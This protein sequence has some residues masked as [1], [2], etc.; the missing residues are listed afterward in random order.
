M[1]CPFRGPLRRG[2]P[3]AWVL[4]RTVVCG[5]V[6]TLCPPSGSPAGEARGEAGLVS[7]PRSL[8]T[9][10]YGGLRPGRGVR[11]LRP[12]RRADVSSKVGG[13][14]DRVAQRAGGE[15]ALVLLPVRPQD[16][17][18]GV[19]RG[20]AGAPRPWCSGAI[21]WS[22]KLSWGPR[23]VPRHSRL[24]HWLLQFA[25]APVPWFLPT[26]AHPSPVVGPM[27]SGLGVSAVS[28]AWPSLL[29][30]LLRMAASWPGQPS[31]D[32]LLSPSCLWT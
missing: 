22:Y 29:L 1:E 25:E 30:S 19:G 16:A 10:V 21:M 17:Q 15:Q 6:W 7:A 23:A 14:L 8:F 18:A 2:W 13:Q 5:L 27:D 32:T 28:Q 4:V 31:G 3:W 20:R 24:L 26:P 9:C 12:A 11:A